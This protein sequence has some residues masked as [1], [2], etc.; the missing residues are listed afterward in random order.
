MLKVYNTRTRKK[1][2]FKPLK[3]GEV[4]MYVCGPTV[5]G[6]MHIGHARTYI[7]F[8]IMR[9]YLE[10]SGFKVNYVM[11][12]T[13]I[14]DDIISKANET[15][16]AFEELIERFIEIFF[17]DMKA[18]EIK[19][20][21][22]YPRVTRHIEEIVHFVKELQEKGFAYETHD[23]VYFDVSKFRGYGK[24]SGVK[25]KKS[26]TGTR[27]ETDKYDK[28]SAQDFALWK[29]AKQGEPAWP[30]PWGN[31]RPGWHIECSVMSSKHIG[32]Q[33]DIH[34]GAVD[35]IFPH[36]E[37]EIAQ[38][39]ARS[40][41]RPFVKYWVHTGF[42]NVEGTKMS[43][44]LGNFI[45][46][47]DLLREINPKAFRFFIG[48]LHY[49]S[50]INYTKKDLEKESK[51]LEA[52]NELIH[53]L[54]TAKGGKENKK[55]SALVEKTM[56]SF[57][58]E[59]DND[60]AFSN[61][62]AVLSKFKTQANKLAAGNKLSE[63]NAKE[64]LEFLRKIDSV[65]GVFTFEKEKQEIGKHELELV[66]KRGELRQQKKWA[67]ADAIRKALAEKGIILDDTPTGTNWK[68]VSK[69]QDNN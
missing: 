43:K 44:S 14:H 37:N 59:M 32:E 61:A 28:A 17:R 34:G 49:K 11:N 66:K 57:R 58:K 2:A 68:L 67:E 3:K 53:R 62:W 12:I 54:G 27:V 18:F 9:R 7:A 25:I 47:P 56:K 63:K 38:S 10:F 41:K 30:S 64:I 39:E 36:H 1:E 52:W 20:A 4:G 21:T 24:L 15:G 50:R 46:V 22:V 45:E 48:Q 5:Q 42:L 23:G 19:P 8:D 26:K 6:P 60:F 13:D 29:K 40:G 65:F 55:V 69:G 33:I 31:G 51:K 16:V 35:L